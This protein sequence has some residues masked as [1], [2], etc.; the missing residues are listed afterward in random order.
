MMDL[1]YS[2][3]ETSL[4]DSVRS[5]LARRSPLETVLRRLEAGEPYD[6]GLWRTLA[7]EMGLAG[8]AV[9]EQ[10]GGGGGTL[11][12]AAVVLEELGRGVAP[13]P[14]LTSA[15]VA[16]A[17]LV[18]GGEAQPDGSPPPPS[19]LARSSALD[20]LAKLAAG[21][22][23]AALAVPFSVGPGMAYAPSVTVDG[24]RLTGRVGAVAG[25]LGADVL[26]V[27]AGDG[28]YAVDAGA[29]GVA[30]APMV[31]LDLT[32]PLA[33]VS[34]D[35]TAGRRVGD[36]GAVAAALTAGAA[37]LASEQL[38]LAE[39][40][41]TTTVQYV[42]ARHQFGRPVGS[43]QALKHR[44]ADVW[45]DLTQARAVARYA[46]GCAAAGDPDLPVAAALAQAF[47]S[48]VAVRAAEECVQMHGGIGFTWE[49]PPHLFL[50]R[51]K[52]AAIA[53]GTAD[54]HRQA[55]G[56]LVGLRP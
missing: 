11:R 15:V 45:A 12:E 24:D 8:M 47:C 16:T 55:L 27:P 41:L 14:F 10:Y 6:D 38:G 53:Y 26:L 39:W 42:K 28:L 2:E 46:A 25:A 22:T 35:G 40:C 7:T 52:S 54:R 5:A 43:Y 17:A 20:L 19:S 1:L 21:E 23:V 31:S 3:V 49:H 4:R 13:V 29:E 51:A 36:D 9:P 32:R 30:R 56:A 18:T 33:E 34:F 48:P 44:L 37:L 50:K